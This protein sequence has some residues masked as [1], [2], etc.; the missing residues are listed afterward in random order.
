MQSSHPSHPRQWERTV[1]YPLADSISLF[2]SFVNNYKR[3]SAMPREPPEE[4]HAPAPRDVFMFTMFRSPRRRPERRKWVGMVAIRCKWHKGNEKYPCGSFFQETQGFITRRRD[5]KAH[6][7]RKITTK[8]SP[9]KTIRHQNH[10]FS[11]TGT[12]YFALFS[13]PK[14]GFVRSTALREAFKQRLTGVIGEGPLKS[15]TPSKN[16]Y[17]T[18]VLHDEPKHC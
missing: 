6:I 7:C 4:Q 14:K 12:L 3:H 10:I 9:N 18:R 5:L 13:L 17:M 15:A 11:K 8:E 1:P 16:P 2:S